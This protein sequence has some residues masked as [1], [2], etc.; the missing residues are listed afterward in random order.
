MTRNSRPSLLG[1]YARPLWRRLILLAASL[2]AVSGLQLVAPQIVRFVI[3]GASTGATPLSTLALAAVVFLLVGL[4]NVG[5]SA[6]SAYFGS[7]VGWRATNRLRSD[8]LRRSLEL[9]LSFHESHSPG[10]L[11][12][13]IDADA[14]ALARFFSTFMLGVLSNVLLLVGVLVVLFRQEWWLG[15]GLAGFATVMV[16]VLAAVRARAV[17]HY[18]ASREAAG[19]QMAFV[20]EWLGGIDDITTSGAVP[21]V[22]SRFLGVGGAAYRAAK[23]ARVLGDALGAAGSTM[24]NLGTVGALVAGVYLHQRGSATLGSVYMI[25]QYAAMLTRPLEMMSGQADELQRAR[26]AVERVG[27]LLAAEPALRSGHVQALPA[28]PQEV[29]VSHV[30][31]RYPGGAPVLED[32]NVVLR[33]GEV[34]GLVGRT[35]S[36]KSTFAKLLCRLQD[37]TSG[38]VTFAGT[39]LRQLSTDTLRSRVGLVTQDVQLFDASVRENLTLFDSAVDDTPLLQA[40]ERLGLSP[41]F[42]RLPE[43]LDTIIASAGR[44]G[45]G[46]SGGEAQLLALTRLCLRDPSL[47]VLDEASSKLDPITERAMG[48][49]LDELLTGRTA[50]VI[51]HRLDTLRRVDTVM[52]LDNGRVKEYGR[53]A[54]LEANPDSHLSALLRMGLAT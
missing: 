25:V 21:Y 14:S 53:R 8:L 35:G 51:A 41:W 2:L 46:L 44:G 4:G 16:V 5:A 32:V 19:Q 6:A 10:E 12:E 47:V 39:D 52:V 54:E 42:S 33:P 9:D 17:P 7:D 3:D 43:G 31:F 38:T 49:A 23:R 26:V 34:L 30:C 28:G 18:R 40:I 20:A 11:I 27:E 36:G 24:L 1:R 13:R 50:M 45:R 15:A 37:P 22:M 48:T 29:G